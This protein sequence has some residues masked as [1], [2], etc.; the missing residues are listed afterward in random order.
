MSEMKSA[1]IDKQVFW[2]AL[3]VVVAAIVPLIVFPEESADVL[4][5]VMAFITHSFGFL[6]LWFT[7]RRP[8]RAPVVCLREVRI[9]QVRRR[10]RA[11]PS[12]GR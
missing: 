4:D 7:L 11:S 8:R 9:G 2:P 12:S 6:F 3:V 10:R 5:R 1:P